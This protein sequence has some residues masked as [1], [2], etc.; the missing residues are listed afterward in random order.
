MRFRYIFC[1]KKITNCVF[2][3]GFSG[4]PVVSVIAMPKEGGREVSYQTS[5]TSHILLLLLLC[6]HRCPS[7]PCLESSKLMHLPVVPLGLGQAWAVT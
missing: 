5:T 1:N 4:S 6:K 2:V 3:W 7:L